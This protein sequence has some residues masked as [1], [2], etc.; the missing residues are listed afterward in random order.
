MDEYIIKDNKKLRMGYTTGTCATA[1]AK[2]AAFMLLNDCYIN[3]IS[4]VRLIEI[5][6]RVCPRSV[7]PYLKMQVITGAVSGGSDVA[8]DLTFLDGLTV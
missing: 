7:L 5:I 2:A 1:A 4:I 6:Q 8:D 3:N